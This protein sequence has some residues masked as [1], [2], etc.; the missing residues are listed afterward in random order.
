MVAGRIANMRQGGDRRSDQEANLPLETR[1]AAADK[2]NVSLRSVGSARKVLDHGVP[3]LVAAVDAGTVA[4][5]A[6]SKPASAEV[7]R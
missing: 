1:A 2:L 7:V 6:T 3:E 4:V 5:S